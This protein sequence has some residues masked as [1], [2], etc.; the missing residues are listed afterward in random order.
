MAVEMQKKL[1]MGELIH[2]EI[3]RILGVK[4]DGP[5]ISMASV[6]SKTLQKYL[7]QSA[8][9]TFDEKVIRFVHQ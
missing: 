5:I 4:E 2:N 7:C 9:R 1:E 6:K 3:K 8:F